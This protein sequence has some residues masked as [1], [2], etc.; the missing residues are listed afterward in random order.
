MAK[1]AFGENTRVDEETEVVAFVGDEC[2]GSAK[3]MY[4]EETGE[5][6]AFLLVYGRDGEEVNFK[7]YSD[8]ETEDAAE[9]LEMRSDAVVGDLE[10]LFELHKTGTVSLYPNPVMV[11]ES[12]RMEVPSGMDLKGSR[13]EVYN[14]LG[15]KVSDETLSGVDLEFTA[16]RVSGVYTVRVTDRKGNVHYGKLVVR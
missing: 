1:V 7:V 8:G 9:T 15:A 16:M 10:T 3:L 14:A 13:V 12:V 6:V 2:R 11:G 5:Y 4:V